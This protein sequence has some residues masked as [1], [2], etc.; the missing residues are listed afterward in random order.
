[1]AGAGVAGRLTGVVGRSL[2]HGEW[3]LRVS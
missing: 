2:C 3:Q 1:V